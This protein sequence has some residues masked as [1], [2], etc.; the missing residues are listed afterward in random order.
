MPSA[1]TITNTSYHVGNFLDIYG[2]N[3]DN[4]EFN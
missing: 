1:E 4:F 3:V 2:S